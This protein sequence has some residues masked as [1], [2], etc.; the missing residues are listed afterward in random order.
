MVI[1]WLRRSRSV[2]A[3]VFVAL[4]A[5]GVQA[6]TLKVP[7]DEFPTIQSA[8]DVAEFGDLIAVNKGIYNEEVT[9][10]QPGIT[11]VGKKAIIDAG[12]EGCCIRVIAAQVTISGFVLVNADIGIVGAIVDDGGLAADDLT[13]TKCAIRSCRIGMFLEGPDPRVLKNVVQDCEQ[14]ILVT[15]EGSDEAV[16]LSRNSVLRCFGVSIEVE[17][18]AVVM[19]RNTIRQ[20]NGGVVVRALVPFTDG[21]QEPSPSSIVDNRI[22]GQLNVGLVLINESGQEML[23]EGN[24]LNGNGRGLE[25]VG[26]NYRIID[27][28]ASRNAEIGMLLGSAEE[29]H[30]VESVVR[31]NVCKN[32]GHE[33]MRIDGPFICRGPPGPPNRFRDNQCQG[34]G[35]DGMAVHHA[36]S[37]ELIDNVCSKNGGDGIDIE[38]QSTTLLL[39]GNKCTK[40]EHEGIDNSGNATM[41]DNTAKGNARGAGP[42]FAGAGDDGD[43]NSFDGGGNKFGSGGFDVSARLDLE[44]VLN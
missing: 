41:R 26:G 15:A 43:G 31:D 30:F 4:L 29:Q 8:V 25:A 10:S 32:N 44:D 11:L 35:R 19:E 2:L 3:V 40:N 17:A 6:D 34:N 12:Y 22:E 20:G 9:I 24:R 13:V 39:E 7:S 1:V 38:F 27:N 37:D 28:E 23:V 21:V 5:V 33:G 36:H 42:D 16:I 18:P 14:G